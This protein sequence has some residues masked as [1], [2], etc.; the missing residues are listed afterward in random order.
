MSATLLLTGCSSY[1]PTANITVG[2]E[3]GKITYK[4]KDTGLTEYKGYE[5]T[6][7]RNGEVYHFILNTDTAT[8]ANISV[9]YQ[10][11]EEANMDKLKGKFYY[12]EYMGTKL[13][14]AHKVADKTFTVGQVGLVSSTK[15][16]AATFMSD[17]MDSFRLT[18]GYSMCDFGPFIFGSGYENVK[19]TTDG[20]SIPATAKVTK[21]SVGCDV[22]MEVV[23]DE[24]GKTMSMMTKETEGYT[25]YEYEGFTI[26]LVK[27][28]QFS[29]YV[30]IK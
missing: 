14:M 27:G 21:S 24:K 16:L 19:V 30:K 13:T 2:W 22:P 17:Y 29:T 11:V 12:T 8:A 9:N 25:Y 28:L 3:D 15:E 18:N 10:G 1:D 5:A 4:G 7:D 6:A 26:Q 20:A 23:I